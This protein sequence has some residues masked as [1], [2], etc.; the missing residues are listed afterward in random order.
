MESLEVWKREVSKRLACLILTK[1]HSVNT[2]LLDSI[3]GDQDLWSFFNQ[4]LQGLTWETS[5][6]Y[7]LYII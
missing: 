6:K 7:G 5:A 4:R 2:L 3:K 1:K